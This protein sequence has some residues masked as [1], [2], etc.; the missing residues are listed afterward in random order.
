MK[1][2][3]ISRRQFGSLT[4]KICGTAVA[5]SV[6]VEQAI[7]NPPRGGDDEGKFDAAGDVLPWHGNTIVSPLPVCSP[8][9]AAM[10]DINR[11]VTRRFRDI[12]S[13]TPPSSY[14]MTIFGGADPRHRANQWWP[15]DLSQDASIDETTRY[16][17]QRL[18]ARRFTYPQ[19]IRMVVD[20]SESLPDDPAV[21]LK[22]ETTEIA[23]TLYKL[24]AVL[25]ESMGLKVPDIRTFRFHVTFGYRFR[26]FSPSRTNAWRAALTTWRKEVA[27]KALVIEFPAPTFCVFD[28]MFAFTPRFVLPR[29][30]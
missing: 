6:M 19:P 16:F 14:H 27:D 22:P 18:G 8:A 17:L 20:T 24:R 5:A 11:E 21:F 13:A 2:R 12:V 25:S 23:E 10:L 9:F 26:P 4:R 15:E 30:D 29:R 3:H 1:I 28:D 7:A